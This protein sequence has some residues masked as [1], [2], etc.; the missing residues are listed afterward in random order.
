MTRAGRHIV[1]R[2][3]ALACSLALAVSATALAQDGEA[4]YAQHCASCH[5]PQGQGLGTF[6]ALA[7][8]AFVTGDE[9]EVVALVLQGRAAMP[10]FAGILDD[11]EIAAVL[12]HVRGAWGNDAGAIDAEVVADLRSGAEEA[13][14]IEVDLPDDWFEL[15]EAAY[16]QN[17]AACHQ[18]SGAGIPGA[19]PALAD[20]AFVQGDADELLRLLLNGRAGMPAFGGNLDNATLALI[21]SYVRSAWGHEAH[22]VDAEMVEVVRGG[23][24]L[25]L[26]PTA[27]TFRPGAGN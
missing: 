11:A 26:E 7:D 1:A 25:E 8:N 14:P 13:E 3:L 16:L 10:A 2:A 15:G 17:C 20:N 6:P 18:A 21:A 9:T 23:G 19:F 24:D 27:P 22:L 4:L 12:T 5:Q